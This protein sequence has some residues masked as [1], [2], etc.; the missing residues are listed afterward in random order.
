MT[1]NLIS[2]SELQQKLS[3]EQSS[4]K[5]T[6]FDT[7][8]SLQEV[9]KGYAD[10]LEGHISG[11]HFLDLDKDLSSK[12]N[13]NGQGGRH[14]LPDFERFE[15][16]LRQ[17]GLN[18][19]HE[20]I[21]YDQSNAVFAGRLWWMLKYMGHD[22]V[23]VLDGGLAAWQ[24]AGYS[25]STQI[26]QTSLGDFT[27][28]LRPH[29]IIDINELKESYQND[30][31]VLI[32][33]RSVER[34]SGAAEPIDAKAGHIPGAKNMCFLNNLEDGKYKP[35]TELEAAYK[36]LIDGKDEVIMYCGSGVSANHNI[37]ALAELGVTE[38][39]RLYVGSWSEWSSQDGVTIS[40]EL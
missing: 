22:N 28:S 3:S 29:M 27:A 21:V 18:T 6:I 30:N 4:E 16:K 10:Y 23:R 15:A 1:S 9:Q 35:L 5:L 2:V 24:K 25:L 39:V 20:V 19:S 37:I 14:P 40:T 12:P 26:P 8:F 33:A 17:L 11:A 38:N 34:Y 13:A 32:D 36:P 7:R 31:T